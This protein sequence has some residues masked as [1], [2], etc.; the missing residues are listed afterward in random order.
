MFLIEGLIV[1]Y[2]IAHFIGDMFNFPRPF[3][4]GVE[5][6]I[7]IGAGVVAYYEYTKAQKA[8]GDTGAMHDIVLD[9]TA[10]DCI[11]A[12]AYGV[13]AL[14]FTQYWA[15]FLS[16][17]MIATCFYLYRRRLCKKWGL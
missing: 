17:S 16:C 14:A 10:R 13:L 6:V 11:S 1:Y 3:P 8:K 7:L 12:L 2:A 15:F 9:N 4:D 5:T